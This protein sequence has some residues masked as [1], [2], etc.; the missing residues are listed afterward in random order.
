VLVVR[1]DAAAVDAI[2]PDPLDPDRR[3]A[4]AKAGVAQGHA[5]AREVADVWGA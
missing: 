5:I 4:A 3:P 1:P 2:G